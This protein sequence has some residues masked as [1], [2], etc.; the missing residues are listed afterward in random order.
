MFGS[1]AVGGRS[2]SSRQSIMLRFSAFDFIL[3]SVSPLLALYLCAAQVLFPFRASEVL[4]YL[5]IS[6]SSSLIAFAAFRVYRGIPGYLCV[7]DVMDMAKAIV[8]A[9]FLICVTMFTVTRLD[10]IPRSVPAI[11]ALILGSG[12]FT[13]RLLAHVADMNRK[14]ANLPPH[15]D[16][17]HLILIGMNDLSVLFM[18]FL[19]VSAPG[20]RNVIALLDEDPRW[21]GRS[22]NGVR[23]YGPPVQLDLLIDEF[24]VHGV[25]A[26]RVVVGGEPDTLSIDTLQEI[27]RVCGRRA[28]HLSFVPDLFNLVSAEPARDRISPALAPVSGYH[29]RTS[30]V[31]APYFRHKRLVETLLA[32]ILI[33]VLSPFWLMGGVLAFFDVGSPVLFWQRRIGI[34]GHPFHVYKLRTLG[35]AL[36]QTGRAIPEEQRVSWIGRLLRRTRIDELPQLVSVLI[37]DMSLIGPR[38][39]LPR[40]QPADPSVRLTVRPGISGWAQVNGGTLLSPEEKEALDAWYIRHASPWLDAR[41]MVMTICSLVRGDRRSESALVQACRERDLRVADVNL[42]F[43]DGASSR[44][45]SAATD[46]ALWDQHRHSVVPSL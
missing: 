34:G 33:V 27:R 8:T 15:P 6:L 18:K 46:P 14:L 39:L 43:Q 21:M 35:H 5:F 44:L 45:A 31:R 30:I 36:D 42:A 1:G 26:D 11:H 32:S 20:S 19:E 38:P 7:H 23:V 37:G 9:E 12:L 17:E 4:I 22:L 2:P 24:A 25:T 28:M 29:S 16:V 41:I 3:A 40:D 10:G 13:A